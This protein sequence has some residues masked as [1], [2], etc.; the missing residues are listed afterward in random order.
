MWSPVVTVDGTL[1][2][3]W[4][5]YDFHFG[6]TFSHCGVD[7]VHLLKTVD[8]WRITALADTYQTTGCPTRPAPNIPRP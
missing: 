1:A 5:P 7:A 4:A 8:G 2:S 6:T 3:I